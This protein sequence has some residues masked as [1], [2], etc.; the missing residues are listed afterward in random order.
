MS[1]SQSRRS[2][3]DAGEDEQQVQP[4]KRFGQHFLT[5]P[6]ILH[7]IV[8]AANV[9]PGDVVL[10]I[11]PGLGSLTRALLE[12][13]AR[14]ASVEIDRDLVRSL[15][16]QARANPQLTVIEGDF[17]T[18]PPHTW[19][20]RAG[21]GQ[22]RYKVVANLPYY[23]TSAILRRLLEAQ[24]QP[25]SMVVMVQREV[26]RQITARPGEMSLLAVSVQFYGEAQM[27]GMVPAGAFRPPPKVDSAIVRVIVQHPSRFPEV[28]PDR[29]FKLVR[30]GFGEKRKQLR[31]SMARS[32][33]MAPE[34]V[35]IKLARARIDSRRRAETLSL[36][37][38]HRI[39]EQFNI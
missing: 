13:G 38:W 4:R 26:A 22:G 34:E 33:Q 29:F 6:N 15:S 39:Y 27:V 12:S 19:L 8:A 35:G 16:E 10:E 3:P 2:P 30:A 9:E 5:D 1:R 11:G 17:L 36:E 7:R 31:N 28:D 37:E 23:I 32:L 20:E 21:I 18:A 14:V 24:Y 25:D